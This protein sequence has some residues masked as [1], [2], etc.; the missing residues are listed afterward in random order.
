MKKIKI[1]AISVARSDYDRFIP[2]LDQL[3]NNEKF[4]LNLFISK[5]H[6]NPKFGRTVR[7]IN[8]RFKIIKNNYKNSEFL[9]DQREN[10]S[11]DL[12]FFNKKIKSIKPDL[13]VVLGD[14]YEMLLGPILAIPNKIPLA[15]FFGGSVTE[16]S[17]DELTRHAITKM[18][19]IH[20][21]A[22]NDYKKR[23]IQLG[24]ESWRIF[25]IGVP[26]LRNIKTTKF[27]KKELLAKKIQFNL[28]KEYALLTYHPTSDEFGRIK[29]NL[30]IIQKIIQK[31][32]LNLVITY[33][34]SDLGNN[35]II[36]YFKKKFK[37]KNKFRI[38]KN[39]GQDKF[40]NIAKY[41]SFMI[42]NSSSGIVESASLKIP[43][44]NLGNRQKGKFHP[45]N[46]V[47]CS[48]NEKEILKALNKIK[49]KSFL[50][51]LIKMKNPYENKK[52]LNIS[53]ILFKMIKNKKILNKKFINFL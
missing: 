5:D 30:D 10:F 35:L 16:G 6:L 11:D 37:D 27:K 53:N 2:I 29:K 52:K 50:N 33:P 44:I 28:N 14:R 47:N 1:V 9:R 41:S 42:G 20:F 15:H 8:K 51:S 31:K 19:H 13:I 21:V 48:F 17:A 24:E 49:S 22:L 43:V 26:S 4:K 25:N 34:N 45:K 46:V 23:L 38:I 3:Q 32:N 40:L 36:N 12:S 39:C 7:F 18:S